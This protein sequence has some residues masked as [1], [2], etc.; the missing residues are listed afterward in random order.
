MKI[1][2]YRG[3]DV[4]FFKEEDF[5]ILVSGGVALRDLDKAWVRIYKTVP[6]TEYF[7]G[8]IDA[9]IEMGNI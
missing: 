8:Y 3:V 2:N 9:L 1:L 4:R 7:E 5:Y 6:T